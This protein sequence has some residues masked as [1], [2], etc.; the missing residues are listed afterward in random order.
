MTMWEPIKPSCGTTPSES[1]LAHLCSKTFLRLWS[2]PNLYRDQR[3]SP[4]SRIGKELCDLL[5]VCDNHLII[6]SDKSCK[7]K[8]SGKL[9]TDWCRWYKKSIRDSANQIKGAERW[10]R[11]FPNQIFIDEQ[12]QQQFPFK[13]QPWDQFSVHRIVVSL[14]AA[15][16]CRAEIGGTGSL[17]INPNIVG[18]DHIKP[19]NEYYQ[20]FSVGWIN[21]ELGYIHVL[22][23]I[24]L[25]IV[26]TAL[27]TVTDFIDYLEKKEAY[28][29]SGKLHWASGEE[30]LLAIYL[31]N[32]NELGKH[33]FPK[34][35]S[36]QRLVV[37]EGSWSALCAN[38]HYQDKCIADQD[39]V[40]W[41]LIIEEFS[42]HVFEATLLTDGSSNIQDHE[43]ALGIM[44]KECRVVRRSLGR[45]IISKIHRVHP[46][47]IGVICM[48]SPNQPEVGYIY[49]LYPFNESIDHDQY[50]EHRKLYLSDCCNVYA[51]KQQHIKQIIG[52]ATETGLGNSGRSHDLLY[53][54]PGE[55]TPDKELNAKGIQKTRGL[56][57]EGKVTKRESLEAEYPTR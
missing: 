6:F 55:W 34:L 37:E 28:I 23:D 22:D 16:R 29:T 47:D 40:I 54:E 2:W 52:I 25:E 48:Q 38:P 9:D 56:F 4:T 3:S 15:D 20:P 45:E 44:A 46:D 41:D 5:V 21:P 53:F 39:S 14:N 31:N 24:T 18:D 57:V 30:D 26:L 35:E 12:C 13:L 36:R 42:R 8:E 32:V 1:F 17:L 49:L 7:F 50:R 33:D 43:L 27:D 51:W 11:D 10:L 19:K